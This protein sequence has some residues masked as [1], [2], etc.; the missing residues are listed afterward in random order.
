MVHIANTDTGESV[1]FPVIP[2]PD[3]DLAEAGWT[4]MMAAHDDYMRD[5]SQEIGTDNQFR[6]NLRFI[7][8]NDASDFAERAL[9]V[10]RDYLDKHFNKK[11]SKYWF[12]TN[13]EAFTS[14][15]FKAYD[16]ILSEVEAFSMASKSAESKELK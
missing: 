16:I 2:V 1:V 15:L 8:D 10:Y 7:Q 13:S 5:V 6:I 12:E 4:A 11:K 14:R 3:I 9:S